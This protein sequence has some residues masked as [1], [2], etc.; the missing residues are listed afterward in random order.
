MRNLNPAQL[1][2]LYIDYTAYRDALTW[3]EKPVAVEEFF[4]LHRSSY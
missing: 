3:P 1:L 4:N 2:R